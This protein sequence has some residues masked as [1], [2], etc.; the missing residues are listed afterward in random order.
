MK[1]LIT[2]L[3]IAFLILGGSILIAKQGDR[4]ESYNRVDYL[5][6]TMAYFDETL[7]EIEE[8]ASYIIKGR[9]LGNAETVYSVINKGDPLFSVVSVEVVEVFKGDVTVGETIRILEPYYINDR[10][11]YTFSNYLPS[12]SNQEYIFFF[13]RQQAERSGVPEISVGAYHVDNQE[14]GRYLVPNDMQIKE[15]RFT[16]NELSLGKLDTDIY[17]D[18]YQD[19][20]DSYIK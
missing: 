6:T 7:D 16:R 18:I 1:R 12:K 2:L 20:I 17:M 13:A 8:R 10:T 15:R 5:A 3:T 9:V 19:V 14:R 11:L 4:Q